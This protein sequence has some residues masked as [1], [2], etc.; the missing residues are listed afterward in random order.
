[1]PEIDRWEN[2]GGRVY[3]SKQVARL[4]ALQ[5]RHTQ[6]DAKLDTELNR[7]NPCSIEVRRLRKEQLFLRDEMDQLS[8]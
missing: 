3:Y 1:M 4:K 6:L 2:E 5:K 7:P 8:S